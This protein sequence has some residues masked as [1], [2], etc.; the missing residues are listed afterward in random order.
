MAARC[1]DL[2]LRRI[3]RIDGIAPRPSRQAAKPRRPLHVIFGVES[4]L[5]LAGG[6]S[7]TLLSDDFMGPAVRFDEA[8]RIRVDHRR[9]LKDVV[10][11]VL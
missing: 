9:D 1:Q 5:N 4:E 7:I 11:D 3:H 6:Q 10:V 2:Q 8:S